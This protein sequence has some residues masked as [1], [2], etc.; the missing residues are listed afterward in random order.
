MYYMQDVNNHYDIKI[1]KGE[2]KAGD[3]DQLYV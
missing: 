3:E 2:V 1:P